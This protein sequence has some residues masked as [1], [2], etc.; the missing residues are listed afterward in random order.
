[1][2]RLAPR[3]RGFAKYEPQDRLIYSDSNC[4]NKCP[5]LAH[6]QIFRSGILLLCAN[7]RQAELLQSV[8]ALQVSCDAM[9]SCGLPIARRPVESGMSTQR[10]R[11]Y[12]FGRSWIGHQLMD[13]DREHYQCFWRRSNS[14]KERMQTVEFI[15]QSDWTSNSVEGKVLSGFSDQLLQKDRYRQPYISRDNVAFDLRI[16]DY[17]AEYAIARSL[18]KGRKHDTKRRATRE[19]TSAFD[20]SQI[21]VITTTTTVARQ[22]DRK[23]GQVP[24][25]TV[26]QYFA[27]LLAPDNWSGRGNVIAEKFLKDLLD[28]D[29]SFTVTIDTAAAVKNAVPIAKTEIV[30]YSVIPRLPPLSEEFRQSTSCVKK[31]APTK[32][33]ISASPRGPGQFPVTVPITYS[34]SPVDDVTLAG[35]P[36]YLAKLR[37]AEKAEESVAQQGAAYN[38]PE[39]H[40]NVEQQSESV[41]LLRADEAISVDSI[42][43]SEKGNQSSEKL[44]EPS[45]EK[46]ESEVAASDQS[47]TETNGSDAATLKSATVGQVH[48]MED[49][50]EHC[51]ERAG[52]AG[53]ETPREKHTYNA[54][55]LVMSTVEQ[56]TC[57]T[58]HQGTTD[59]ERINTVSVQQA[60]EDNT[61]SETDAIQTDIINRSE[62]ET[63][64]EREPIN[65]PV[66]LEQLQSEQ[67]Q[68]RSNIEW[69]ESGHSQTVR[70]ASST[71]MVA[72]TR[73]RG[74]FESRPL[75]LDG[76][77]MSESTERQVQ[78]PTEDTAGG[79]R[80]SLA[81]LKKTLESVVS[82]QNEFQ[83]TLDFAV[84]S[85]I[86]LEKELHSLRF[87]RDSKIQSLNKAIAQ[88][89]HQV[90]QAKKVTSFP[91][92]Y[93]S[94][95]Q[96]LK[97]AVG[98]LQ[99]QLAQ[100]KTDNGVPEDMS[101]I[102]G[103][104]E[105]KL[106][107]M[108]IENEE[109]GAATLSEGE[110]SGQQRKRGVGAAFPANVKATEQSADTLVI[111]PALSEVRMKIVPE[112]AKQLFPKA[113]EFASNAFGQLSRSETRRV[114]AL[115]NQ[116]WVLVSV[117]QN[118]SLVFQK[119][120][121][122]RLT[123]VRLAV[124]VLGSVI[125]LSSVILTML[126]GYGYTTMI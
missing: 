118:G 13:P 17:A 26:K 109:R 3:P 99:H 48:D 15:L 89:Q 18:H 76:F 4:I 28:I 110:D 91:N 39:K 96:Y 74:T 103:A 58:E 108:N 90:A 57:H 43:A 10:G 24:A 20:E 117:A 92:G 31:E 7:M 78:E 77:D 12:Y 94:E 85:Q 100:S 67:K 50:V 71:R 40:P 44:D 22:Y 60:T 42:A 29:R 69:L 104:D 105:K 73:R 112:F 33:T 32:D 106:E 114:T 11:R 21:P 1:M 37:D 14:R 16:V 41:A 2:S 81:V 27:E 8:S 19:R 79:Y 124:K 107:S 30:P 54:T 123:G 122:R 111:T 120:P 63:V 62:I 38:V 75:N 9:R 35:G 80:E 116:G 68:I 115:A 36:L 119:R 25:S 82:S 70:P 97:N 5:L 59:S 52:H 84:S 72:A 102:E 126:V 95:I 47:K 66:E 88:L 86:D 125:V 6:L 45:A 34:D 46:S 113:P 93:E 23:S 65:I 87:Y 55:E 83:A 56:P 98:Q 53:P 121:E 101:A 64:Q 49:A 51:H 61:R